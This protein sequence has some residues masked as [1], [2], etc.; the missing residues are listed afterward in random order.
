MDNENDPVNPA[1][2]RCIVFDFGFTLSSD[3]YF[4]VAP[5]ECPDFQG[6]FQRH[7]FSDEAL[8][9]AWMAGIVTMQDIAEKIA[10]ITDM[11]VPRIVEFMELGCRDLSFNEAV[12]DFAIRQRKL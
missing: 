3:L 4:K 8:I 6:I 7:I 9:D 12:L 2:I 1:D 11:Q 10:S 5:P